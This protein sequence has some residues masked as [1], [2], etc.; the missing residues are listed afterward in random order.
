M[1]CYEFKC[2]SIYGKM[3][4]VINDAGKLRNYS[5]LSRVRIGI[6][7]YSC[8]YRVEKFLKDYKFVIGENPSR[9]FHKV[10]MQV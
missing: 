3:S 9:K 7:G 5:I 1:H 10:L 8:S 4:K 2:A 6:I